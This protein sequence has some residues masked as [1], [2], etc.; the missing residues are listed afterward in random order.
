MLL[1]RELLPFE[2][3]QYMLL[4]RSRPGFC[5]PNPGKVLLRPQGREHNWL[6]KE[7]ASG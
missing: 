7:P 4:L 6:V 3:R 1:R 5:Q 2:K